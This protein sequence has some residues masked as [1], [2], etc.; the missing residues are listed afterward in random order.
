MKLFRPTRFSAVPH[1]KNC[2]SVP[3]ARFA[4]SWFMARFNGGGGSAAAMTTDVPVHVY[5]DNRPIH[6]M[7]SKVYSTIP[8]QVRHQVPLARLGAHSSLVWI[9]LQSHQGAR[10]A[11]SPQSRS[12]ATVR[13][14]HWLSVQPFRAAHPSCTSA[15]QSSSTRS[16]HPCPP[17]NS[18]R[19]SGHSHLGSSIY[20][21]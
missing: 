11:T 21:V 15:Q 5:L 10:A 17:R 12:P 16:P 9:P 2:I 20:I 8:R 6:P 18:R 3:K 19:H 13:K 7:D 4:P 1:R 14:T